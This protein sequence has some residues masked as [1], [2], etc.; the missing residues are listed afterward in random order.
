MSAVP[1]SI[2]ALEF[3]ALTLSTEFPEPIPLPMSGG[4][5]TNP[6]NFPANW[7]AEISIQTRWQ[8]DVTR[9]SDSSRTE[10]WSLSSRPSKRM[11][12]KISGLSKDES[13]AVL[14][15]AFRHTEAFG[16]PVPLY[17]DAVAVTSATG[18]VIQGDFRRRRFFTNGRVVVFPS[19]HTVLRGDNVVFHA[20]LKEITPTAI[21]ID[22]A[23][24]AITNLDMVVPCFDAELIEQNSGTSQTNDLWETEI[25]WNEVEGAS[26]LPALWPACT[27]GN[28]E[29][30]SPVC[31]I[32]D[33]LPIFP[34]DPN[35]ADGIDVS[36]SRDME[37]NPSG[38]SRIQ[39]PGGPPFHTIRMTLTGYD[40]ER[41]WNILRF[42]D[43]M[44]GRAGDF[45]LIHPLRPWTFNA[46]PATDRAYI[47]AVGS[48]E[49]ILFFRKVVL[50]RANGTKITRHINDVVDLG[51]RFSLVFSVAL[52]DTAF[53]DVQPIMV[54]NF[55]SDTIEESWATTEVIP[56]MEVV[57]IEN[58]D[59]GPTSATN[60][61][62]LLFGPVF[63]AFL[64]IEGL[65]L[66]FRAGTGCARDDGLISSAVPS[67]AAVPRSSLDS[68]V[69]RWTDNSA[70]PD[71]QQRQ[72]RVP[73]VLVDTTGRP[74]LIRF[75]Q[76]F[77]NNKQLSIL[78][79]TFSL[80]FQTLTTTPTSQRSL[81]SSDG[82][83][84][85]I[86]FSP[87]SFNYASSD[88]YLI[89]IE[90]ASGAVFSL[91]IDS[92][93]FTG[94]GRVR[95][96]AKDA[97]GGGHSTG[98]S[99]DLY[100]P[101]QFPAAVYITVRVSASDNKLRVWANGQQALTASL[102]CP[103]GLWLSSIYTISQWFGG[104]STGPNLPEPSFL[105]D[106]FGKFGC[107]NLLVSY[108]RPL[109]IDDVNKVH[110]IVSDMF[111]TTKATSSLYA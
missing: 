28:A 18:L 40:R 49:G 16:S 53:V 17:P 80:D 13:H 41:S 27:P 81:W 21:T 9:P 70:G 74:S 89:R 51:D 87:T 22:A 86:C 88:R 47:K 2:F 36:P 103:G 110:L 29:I 42:F 92:N 19:R 76:N 48:V 15:A 109:D 72:D 69:A 63:P 111:R 57:M 50:T 1:G 97:A 61:T 106:L 58:T 33:G 5:P 93:G 60:Q 38:R 54:C 20:I 44:R 71:R 56:S 31:E 35:W 104:L 101:L 78:E 11:K 55:E 91:R 3:E 30:L 75:P 65:N 37:S 99:V 4:L 83:T 12:A 98:F 94:P 90:D 66:L 10:R 100:D 7:E 32:L 108:D 39:S 79:P 24:R 14:Q 84:V 64:E 77:E 43:S 59:P 105:K 26:A 102:A 25:E 46:V 23:P 67:S 62:E 52:P 8:T 95:V 34:F 85:T 68:R 73:R 6:L 82:W 96:A 107:A 45:Y